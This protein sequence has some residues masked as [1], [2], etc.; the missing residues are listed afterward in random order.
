MS[1][2]DIISVAYEACKKLGSEI[3]YLSE[4]GLIAHSN[5]GMFSWNAELKIKVAD[6][7]MTLQSES[8]GSEMIDWGKN[9]KNVENFILTFQELRRELSAE[10]VQNTYNEIKECFTPAEADILILPPPTFKENITNSLALFK[11]TAGYFV[12]PVLI[13]INIIMFI[14]MVLGGVSFISPS[15]ESLLEW[16]GNFRPR[17]LD[18]EIWRL[19]TCCF[20]HIGIIHLL[21]NLYALLYIGVLLEPILGRNK[22][23]LAYLL[24]GVIA[25]TT[26]LWWH[27]YTVSAGAS[28]AIFGMYGVFLA[29]LTTNLIEKTARKELLTSISVFVGYNLLF[30]L[31][32]SIDNA[33]HIGGL[34]SGMIVGYAFYPLMI[35]TPSRNLKYSVYTSLVA[36][37]IAVS[38]LA[39]KSISNDIGNF[40]KKMEEFTL[41]EERALN[42]YRMPETSSDERLLSFIKDTGLVCWYKNLDLIKESEQ[43]DIPSEFKLRNHLLKKYCELRIKSYEDIYKAIS[44]NTNVYAS[45]IE[46]SNKEI[47]SIIDQLNSK[48]SD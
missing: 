45:Q 10:Q 6:Q 4:N 48:P 18:G 32:G 7:E 22:F 30:G 1:K 37:T 24:T 9:K 25:S 46:E 21:F 43:L 36:A 16:G 39:Y 13:N 23:A 35:Q 5:K 14:L 28:G 26:S 3:Q 42:L 29:M 17:T 33:A 2:T 8:T 44:E 38:F 31:Q 40:E 20:V 19:I 15:G 27:D 34:L 11:P 47:Q 12:T 41:L